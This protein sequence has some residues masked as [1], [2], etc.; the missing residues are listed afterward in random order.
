[1]RTPP[2]RGK[3]RNS[4]CLENLRPGS[5]RGRSRHSSVSH[6][7]RACSLAWHSACRQGCR[8][9]KRATTLALRS[10]TGTTADRCPAV[11]VHARGGGTPGGSDDGAGRGTHADAPAL[12]SASAHA[13]GNPHP[14]ARQPL[15]SPPASSG[16]LSRLKSGCRSMLLRPADESDESEQRAGP[17]DAV[18]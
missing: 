18:Q 16:P 5:G 14:P 6:T 13:L 4:G 11:A 10:G 7:A 15:L 3:H 1:M 2:T 17:A 8:C 9:R 12:A